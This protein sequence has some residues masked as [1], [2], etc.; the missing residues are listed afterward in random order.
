MPTDTDFAAWWAQERGDYLYAR[1]EPERIARE[2]WEA[3]TAAER[4]RMQVFLDNLSADLGDWMEAAGRA[5]V[6]RRDVDRIRE[7]RAAPPG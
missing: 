6:T 5:G 2:T 7:V 4:A 3:A 1:D